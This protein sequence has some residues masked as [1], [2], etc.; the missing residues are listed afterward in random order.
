M[1][2]SP[3]LNFSLFLSFFSLF[4]FVRAYLQSFSG[5]FF[6]IIG[7]KHNGYWKW[8]QDVFWQ[9]FPWQISKVWHLPFSEPF[10]IRLPNSRLFQPYHRMTP[11][12]LLRMTRKSIFSFILISIMH[13]IMNAQVWMR[14]H[15]WGSAEVEKTGFQTSLSSSSSR[16][17]LQPPGCYL[18]ARKK[19]GT[20]KCHQKV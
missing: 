16:L 8:N 4:P 11:D 18:D 9:G 6:I 10:I 20:Q 15:A 1:I 19:L 5:H 3:F 13:V 12:Y 2:F 14:T 7:V 17:L